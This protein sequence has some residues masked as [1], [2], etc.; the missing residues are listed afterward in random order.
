MIMVY[1]HMMISKIMVLLGLNKFGNVS[2]DKSIR[3]SN[4]K[5]FNF[6]GEGFE[7]NLLKIGSLLYQNP[8][9]VD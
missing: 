7:I 9:L 3:F 8:S 6:S 4:L 1:V 5:K 2:N